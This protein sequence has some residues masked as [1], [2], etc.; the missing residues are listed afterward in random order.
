MIIKNHKRDAYLRSVSVTLK[1]RLNMNLLVGCCVKKG[2]KITLNRVVVLKNPDA[3]LVAGGRTNAP[4]RS[5]VF[6]RSLTWSIL[7]IP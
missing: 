3:C 5:M 6:L 2:D 7:D 4:S 1:R